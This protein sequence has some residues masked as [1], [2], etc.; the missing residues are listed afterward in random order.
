MRNLKQLPI[1]YKCLG[2][3]SPKGSSDNVKPL[4]VLNGPSEWHGLRQV[5]RACSGPKSYFG[6]A[7]RAHKIPLNLGCLLHLADTKQPENM[8]LCPMS[9]F[10]ALRM[11][12]REPLSS[13][14]V[15]SE[16]GSAVAG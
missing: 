4:L 8:K 2:N 14:D 13:C 7:P 3:D 12:A 5:P 6:E 10:M 16:Q 15:I 9:P 1:F 11:V